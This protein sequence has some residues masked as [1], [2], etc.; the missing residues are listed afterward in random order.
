MNIEFESV[1]L[2]KK[3]KFQ[4]SVYYPNALWMYDILGYLFLRVS[5]VGIPTREQVTYNL[6]C[7]KLG[8]SR[9]IPQTLS[10]VLAALEI[11]TV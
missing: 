11:A 5:F 7:E 4:K 10:Q 9:L 1:G 2:I 3:K 6:S 8:F